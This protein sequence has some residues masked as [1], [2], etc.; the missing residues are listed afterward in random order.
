MSSGAV[1]KT[2][3]PDNEAELAEMVKAGC[4]IRLIFTFGTCIWCPCMLWQGLKQKLAHASEKKACL[5]Q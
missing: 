5:L 2:E 1:V 3:L 4:S